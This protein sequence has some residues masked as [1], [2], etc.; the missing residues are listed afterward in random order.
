M[1]K[2]KKLI[3]AVLALALPLQ[4][5]TAQ[6]ALSLDECRKLAL[7]QNKGLAETRLEKDVAAA[8]RRAAQTNYLPKVQGVAGYMRVGKE[9]SILNNEQKHSL[10]TMGTQLAGAAG[11]LLQN[12]QVQ[13]IIARHPDLAPL[14]GQLEG[15]IAAAG[16]TLNGVGHD[17]VNA[18]RT[19]NRNMTAAAILLTQPLYMGGKIRAYDRITALQEDLAEQRVRQEEAAVLY[20]VDCAYWQVVSLAHKLKLARKYRATLQQLSDNVDRLM[21]EGVA[22]RA[23]R[24]QV[25]VKLNEADMMLLKVDDGLLLSRMLLCQL[26]GLAPDGNIVTADEEREDFSAEARASQTGSDTT[27]NFERRPELSQLEIATSIYDRKVDI[28]RSDFLPSLALTAGYMVS[29]PSTFNGFQKKFDGTWSLGLVLKVPIWNWGEGRYKVKAAKAEAQM[30]RYK[31]D[32]VREKISLQVTQARLRSDEAVRKLGLADKN[33]ENADE[34]L[35][36]ASLG[37]REGFIVL[38]DVLQ[39]ETAWLQAHNDRIDAEIDIMLSRTAL[40]KALGTLEV[41]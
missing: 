16:N 29:N 20:D 18:F 10:N 3:I 1:H 14:L 7:E 31:A 26:C 24:L 23:N 11:Q 32:D 17:V 33:L 27:D 13:Q 36:I 34:N 37:Y 30:A 2:P 6:Q 19:D 38:T 40:L 25:S 28:V 8:T 41:N 4:T 15:K 12:P 5:L 21:K 35:R 22:T 9:L 39:A